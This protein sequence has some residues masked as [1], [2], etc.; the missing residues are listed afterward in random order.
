MSRH[1]YAVGALRG[2][3]PRSHGC[4]RQLDMAPGIELHSQ[5]WAILAQVSPNLMM[6][7]HR[8]PVIADSRRVLPYAWLSEREAGF[9]SVFCSANTQP[10]RASEAPS[11]APRRALHEQIKHSCQ[12]YNYPPA[13]GCLLLTE[14]QAGITD[15]SVIYS[16]SVVR[17]E[18]RNAAQKRRH[19]VPGLLCREL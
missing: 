5:F 1:S 6:L 15:L 12:L 13:A 14:P 11:K 17:N 7:C 8:T 2:F 16:S 10:H 18:H 4:R 3:R 19:R 9:C